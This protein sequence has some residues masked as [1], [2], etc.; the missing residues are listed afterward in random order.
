VQHQIEWDGF[1]LDPRLER[2]LAVVG[3]NVGAGTITVER[4]GL[5]SD[6]RIDWRAGVVAFELAELPL[7]GQEPERIAHL[8]AQAALEIGAT[9]AAFE[10]IPAAQ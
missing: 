5:I 2:N 9:R 1:T 4:G 8:G 10:A 6:P 7:P 3:Q